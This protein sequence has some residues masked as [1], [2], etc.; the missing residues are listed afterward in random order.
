[1]SVPTSPSGWQ[2]IKAAP[3][4]GTRILLGWEQQQAVIVARWV[5]PDERGHLTWELD[6]DGCYVKDP[7]H[8]MP[9]PSPPTS[10]GDDL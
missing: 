10:M 4:D 5:D 7:S 6:E 9:L 1:M 3:K 2:P 8:W